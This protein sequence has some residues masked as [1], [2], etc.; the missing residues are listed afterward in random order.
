MYTAD[1]ELAKFV[2]GVVAKLADDLNGGLM[3]VAMVDFERD[4]VRG[5]DKARCEG[6]G[7]GRCEVIASRAIGDELLCSGAHKPTEE[8][9]PN[10]P[11]I[12]AMREEKK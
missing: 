4:L 5:R 10:G 7:F 8:L 2:S 6:E 11:A 3:V 12:N 9:V 1:A